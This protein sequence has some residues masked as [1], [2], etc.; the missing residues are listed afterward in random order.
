M[1]SSSCGYPNPSNRFRS[2]IA[3]RVAC[4][5]TIY[6]ASV[7]ESAVM[8]CFFEFHEISP[9]PNRYVCPDTDCQSSTSPA[10][11]APQYPTRVIEIPSGSSVAVYVHQD[12]M[13]R[14]GNEV[15]FSRWPSV[16]LP[17]LP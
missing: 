2:Q 10:K 5:I 1:V 13:S 3:W 17:D 15:R 12:L 14:L 11:S 4:E 6:S 7:L 16:L 8:V 9:P